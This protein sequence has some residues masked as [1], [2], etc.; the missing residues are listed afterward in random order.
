MTLRF[1]AAPGIIKDLDEAHD[2]QDHNRFYLFVTRELVD[3]I[4]RKYK[5]PTREEALEFIR[6]HLFV[7]E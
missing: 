2:S 6:I 5:V 3:Y 4:M 1:Y 7:K